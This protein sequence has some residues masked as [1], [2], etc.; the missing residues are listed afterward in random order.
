MKNYKVKAVAYSLG[1]AVFLTLFCLMLN[2]HE[3]DFMSLILLFALAFV[4]SMIMLWNNKPLIHTFLKG[5]DDWLTPADRLIC[6]IL[7]IITYLSARYVWSNYQED[8][9]VN[10]IAIILGL[11]AA[12]GYRTTYLNHAP[13][14]IE[15]YEEDRKRDAEVNSYVTVAECKDVESARI[16]KS[17]LESNGIEASTYGES[18]PEFLGNVPV[19]VIVRRKDQEAA[20]RIIN[21]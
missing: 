5:H 21:E 2:R 8:R 11:C 3:N 17:L 20:E 14:D 15:Q 18:S 13:D 9:S 10:I 16:I 4:V 1:L 12:F 19:R 7:I 6:G